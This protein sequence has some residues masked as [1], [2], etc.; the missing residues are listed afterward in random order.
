[1]LSQTCYW[2]GWLCEVKASAIIQ[3]QSNYSVHRVRELHPFKLLQTIDP[4]SV[5]MTDYKIRAIYR[6]C[7]ALCYRFTVKRSLLSGLIESRLCL[8]VHSR[9]GSGSTKRLRLSWRTAHLR[10]RGLTASD[11][12]FDKRPPSSASPMTSLT[13]PSLGSSQWRS[14]K[15]ELGRGFDPF[16]FFPLPSLLPLSFLPLPFLNSRTPKIP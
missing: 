14:Q 12:R 15:C 16:S 9:R 11:I 1:M 6:H 7:A 10:T 3:R 8:G 4:H 13:R 5:I 2:S